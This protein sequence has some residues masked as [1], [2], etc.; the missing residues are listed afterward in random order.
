MQRDKQVALARKR[1]AVARDRDGDT[2][3]S[4]EIE[5][6]RLD[7]EIK[8]MC[9]HDAIYWDSRSAEDG[10]IITTC[11]RCGVSWYEHVG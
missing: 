5:I 4:R 3:A 1:D 6:I 2:G 10:R 9:T 7:D 8:A 11:E